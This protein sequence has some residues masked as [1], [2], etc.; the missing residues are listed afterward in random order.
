MPVAVTQHRHQGHDAG[1]AGNKAERPA[2]GDGPNEIAANRPAQLELVTR[3]KVVD[4][5]RRD[6]SIFDALD[7]QGGPR[8]D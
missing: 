6:F 2:L 8:L 3:A 4:E 1:A 7:G 5:V